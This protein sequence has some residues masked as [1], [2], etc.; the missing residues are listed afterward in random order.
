MLCLVS[1]IMNYESLIRLFHLVDECGFFEA[2]CS[3][4]SLCLSAMES[5]LQT[6]IELLPPLFFQMLVISK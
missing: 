5:P 2:V 1:Q 6:L 4:Y 3:E